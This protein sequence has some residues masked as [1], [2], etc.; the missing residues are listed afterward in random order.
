[1]YCFLSLKSSKTYYLYEVL[2]I[3]LSSRS[4]SEAK[5]LQLFLYKSLDVTYSP[6][7]TRPSHMI[8]AGFVS[9]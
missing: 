7:I 4:T 6:L 2:K 9:N 5:L 8:S 3:L 1:M